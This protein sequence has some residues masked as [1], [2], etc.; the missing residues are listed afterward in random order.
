VVW[1]VCVSG[2]DGDE[3]VGADEF[4]CVDGG[5]GDLVERKML[6]VGHG[7]SDSDDKAFAPMKDNTVSM[8]RRR[9][10]EKGDAQWRSVFITALADRQYSELVEMLEER[11][12]R[13]CDGAVEGEGELLDLGAT[14][15]EVAERSRQ[16][17]I[18]AAG[19]G[20][21]VGVGGT[22][23]DGKV[24]DVAMIGIRDIADIRDDRLESLQVDGLFL[25]DC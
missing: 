10:R 11:D 20:V 21:G 24:A 13:L 1:D 18:T 9:E 15:E 17:T 12:D 16:V 5:A 22:C 19:G 3:G 7:G 2:D 25:R 23:A 14:G 4:G 6:Q 8:D